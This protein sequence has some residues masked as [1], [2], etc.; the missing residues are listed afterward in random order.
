MEKALAQ[1]HI[2]MVDRQAS[3]GYVRDLESALATADVS[4][5]RASLRSFVQAVVLTGPRGDHPLHAAGASG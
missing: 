1:G 3:V 5:R 4:E 2:D